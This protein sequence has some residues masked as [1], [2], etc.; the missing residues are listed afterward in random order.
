MN[1]DVRSVKA[2]VRGEYWFTALSAGFQQ[3]TQ[4]SQSVWVADGVLGD[5]P[6]RMI[7][8]V[9]N[10]E[11]QFPRARAGEVGSWFTGRLDFGKSCG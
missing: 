11:N 10:T 9:V 1:M 7:A 4:Y 2:S 5:Q 3:Q 6:T 8:V